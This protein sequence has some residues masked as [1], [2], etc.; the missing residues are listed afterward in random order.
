[1]LKRYIPEI[2]PDGVI[3]EFD[4]PN[5]FNGG[6]LTV[7]INGK[8]ENSE[9]KPQD[10]FGYVVNVIN[11]TFTF[12]EPLYLE[13]TL[14][15]I[16]DDDGT[17]GE[18]AFSNI[19]WGKNIVKTVWVTSNTPVPF[20]ITT[21]KVNFNIHKTIPMVWEDTINKVNFDIVTNRIKFVTKIKQWSSNG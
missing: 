17:L 21:N 12:Y 9:N 10:T 8:L 19:D 14:L 1:M 16:Y 11:K 15:V 13:D 4:L 7:Y 2:L 6:G 3:T 20:V 18:L 5:S